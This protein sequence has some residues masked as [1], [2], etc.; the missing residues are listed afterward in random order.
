MAE[1]RRFRRTSTILFALAVVVGCSE[2]PDLPDDANGEVV[3][4]VDGDTLD[5][6]F[7]VNGRTVIERV[8]LIGIDTPE[9]KKPGVPVECFGP[10]ASRRLAELVPIGTFVD[11]VRDVETRDVY[12]RLL[13]Y[14]YRADDRL[15]VNE[16]L[17]REGYART[18][19]IPPN[20]GL[21]N[22]LRR[23]ERAARS[24]G[25]GLWSACD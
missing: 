20:T 22:D 16:T 12:D 6:A 2:P 15:F 19:F 18:L 23:A 17:V 5:I 3:E 24:G 21:E 1:S 7:G 14:V 10:E 4:L 9:T 11:V 25:R 13:A 8:R